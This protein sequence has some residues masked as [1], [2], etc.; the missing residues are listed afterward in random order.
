M[1]QE[2]RARAEQRALVRDPVFEGAGVPNGEDRPVLVIPGFLAGD[3]S[4]QVLR[5]W[6]IR[7]GYQPERS[8]ISLNVRRSDALVAALSI[9]AQALMAR[10]GRPVTV[11]GHSRGGL[12]AKVLADRN[13]ELVE[14][15]IALGSPLA[16]PY[17]VHPLTLAAAQVVYVLNARDRRWGRMTER[18]FLADLA[19]P[20]RVP[21]TSLYSRTD[22]VVNWHAC[23]RPDV[24]G[25][26]VHG[27]HGGLVLN[28]EVYRL[29]ARLLPIGGTPASS[30]PREVG[31]VPGGAGGEGRAAEREPWPRPPSYLPP[32]AGGGHKDL[33]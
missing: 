11:V 8:G 18:Q 30:L 21:V 23:L 15:V 29:L 13:P 22:G 1:W 20:P 27:S 19:A 6:L 17:D 9:R 32:R 26:E 31:G 12:L 33:A 28:L 24:E 10:S 4:V 16:D 7:A 5:D 3:A 25:I 2:A 14:R